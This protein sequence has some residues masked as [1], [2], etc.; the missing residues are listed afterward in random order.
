M[1]YRYIKMSQKIKSI[2]KNITKNR[3]FELKNRQTWL[4]LECAKERKKKSAQGCLCILI[5]R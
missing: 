2:A 5:D 4:S 3:I 1:A